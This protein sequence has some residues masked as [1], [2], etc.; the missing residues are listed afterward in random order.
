MNVDLSKTDL[1]SLIELIDEAITQDFINES[2]IGPDYISNDEYL[3]KL[4]S[5]LYKGLESK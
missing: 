5:K 1:Y 3:T 4:K 2:N